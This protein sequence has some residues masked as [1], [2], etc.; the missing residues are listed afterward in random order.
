MTIINIKIR[1]GSMFPANKLLSLIFSLIILPGL[2]AAQD[3]GS[4][5]IN[6]KEVDTVF[7]QGLANLATG[8]TISDIVVRHVDVGEEFMG[9]SVVQRDKKPVTEIETGIAHVDLDEIYYVVSGE[10]TMVT[11]GEFV[12]METSHSNLLGDMLRGQIVGGV[13]QKVKP[14]DI[15]IIPKGMPHGWHEIVTDSIG[16]IIFRGDPNKVMDEVY[17]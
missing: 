16:Y 9:V 14:G 3:D 15:A 6:K 1:K 7:E 2:V 13:L 10:G 11:G 4:I 12:D 17:K 8:R 5:I